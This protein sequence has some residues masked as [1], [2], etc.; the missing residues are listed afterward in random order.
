MKLNNLNFHLTFPPDVKLLSRLMTS[1]V[2]EVPL[3]KEEISQRTGIPT[4]KSSGKVEPHIKYAEYMGLLYDS[5]ANGKHVLKKTVLGDCISLEDPSLS[6]DVS[7]MVCYLRMTGF[8]D[9]A[10]LWETIM[11]EIL[12]R[13]RFQMT[14]TGLR[15]YLAKET[16]IV[17]NLSPFYS[18]FDSALFSQL[19]I[20]EHTK[21]SLRVLKQRYDPE[22]LYVYAYAFFR[23]W[24]HRYPERDELTADELSSFLMPGTLGWQ[25]QDFYSVMESMEEKN[26]IVFNRQ[27]VPYTVTKCEKSEAMIAR[28]YS[29]LC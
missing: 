28:L 19:K 5:V 25:G 7:V 9:G 23:E 20:L 3:T 12:P 27:L 22:L 18:S 15:N 11:G 10:P 26:L 14:E 8:L 13:N 24:E 21:E 2:F 17:V 16:D 29:E 4:G 1:E 6:E